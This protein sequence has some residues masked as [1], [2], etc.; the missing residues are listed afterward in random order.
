M[1]TNCLL[2]TQIG[3][4][5]RNTLFIMCIKYKEAVP[6]LIPVVAGTLAGAC[7]LVVVIVMAIYCAGRRCER[8]TGGHTQTPPELPLRAVNHLAIGPLV[9]HYRRDLSVGRGSDI[10]SQTRRSPI[11]T[12]QTYI[13]PRDSAVYNYGAYD[14]GAV[15][16]YRYLRPSSQYTQLYENIGEIQCH[17]SRQRDYV[18]SYRQHERQRRVAN[19]RPSSLYPHPEDSPVLIRRPK[20]RLRRLNTDSIFPNDF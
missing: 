15:K 11:N 4:D 5:P 12:G 9:A 10:Q 8:R 18:V 16:H 13:R 17:D 3:A 7:A 1:R 14:I 20:I 2:Q 19:E 6:L